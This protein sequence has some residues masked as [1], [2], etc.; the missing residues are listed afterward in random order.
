LNNYDFLY[1]ENAGVY[2]W[3]DSLNFAWDCR[4]RVEEYE[5]AVILPAK[6]FPDENSTFSE[7]PGWRRCGGVVDK[8]GKFVEISSH[9]RTSARDK[10]YHQFICNSYEFSE[11]EVEFIDR[12]AV[13]AGYCFN[14][15]GHFLVEF[16]AR[17]YEFIG[18]NSDAMCVFMHYHN[19]ETPKFVMEFTDLL[20]IPRNNVLCIQK[21]TRFK[22][23]IVPEQS[24]IIDHGYA[25][26]YLNIIE[27]FKSA[28]TI[29]SP[30][31]DKVYFSRTKFK[32]ESMHFTIGEDIIE[33]SFR[34]KGFDIVYPET[35]SI[36]EQIAIVKG[37]KIFAG[38]NSS[39]THNFIF[40]S[41]G[42]RALIL[43]NF[44][45]INKSQSIINGI[46]GG[47]ITWIDAYYGFLPSMQWPG[48]FWV[49][50]NKNLQNALKIKNVLP[51]LEFR[52]QF[53]EYLRVWAE[54]HSSPQKFSMISSMDE[55]QVL[56]KMRMLI[57]RYSGMEEPPSWRGLIKL[58]VIKLRSIVKYCLKM[59]H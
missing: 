20:G 24:S 38:L 59:L 23:V 39:T 48:P 36:A 52:K 30:V 47:K 41:C 57:N 5:K 6:D 50:L 56:K 9:W 14:H 27:A 3:F 11:S 54:V 34:T 19:S 40:A 22:K 32:S 45:I 46:V 17:L 42:T 58:L 37:A 4:C 26:E 1:P 13:Y 12:E 15:Y 35:L 43:N 21:P 25:P 53:F 16:A 29:P 31:G 55:L 18:K 28:V 10:S 44:N 8:N 7:R 49:T 51:P 2:K 33:D